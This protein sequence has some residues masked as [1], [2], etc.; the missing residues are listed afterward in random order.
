MAITRFAGQA[1]IYAESENEGLRK[2]VDANSL[3]PLQNSGCPN[4]PPLSSCRARQY[5]LQNQVCRG[6]GY[7][8][9]LEDFM[10]A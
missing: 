7:D 5:C 1:E 8:N 9:G 2:E 4:V 10:P 3:L 6:Y